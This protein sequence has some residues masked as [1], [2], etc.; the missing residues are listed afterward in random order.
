VRSHL[1]GCPFPAR[2]AAGTKVIDPQIA[3]IFTD[4]YGL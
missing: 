1:A 4:C 3:Q 2:R